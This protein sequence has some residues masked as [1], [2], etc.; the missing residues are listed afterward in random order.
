MMSQRRTAQQLIQVGNHQ[1]ALPGGVTVADWALE[2]LHWQNPRIRAF[3]GCIRLL[4]GV[5]ESNYSLLHCSPERLLD[6]WSRVRKLTDLIRHRLAPLLRG[7]SRIPLLEE[8][9]KSAELSLELLAC[10][11]LD[12]LDRVPEPVPSDQLTEIRKLLCISIGQLHAFLHDTFGELMAKDPRSLHDADYFLSRRFPQ[13]IE[14]AEWLHGT[15]ARLAEYV[16][17]L[18]QVRPVHLSAVATAM[19]ETG[20]V[21]RA[22]AWEGTRV[23]VDVLLHGLSPKLREVLALRGVR[24]QE[25]EILDRYAVE[26]P[27]QCRILLEI[28]ETAGGAAAA[29]EG[30]SGPSAAERAQ[31]ARSLRHAQGPPCHRMAELIDL[32]DATLRDLTA[33]LPL[34][35]QG[36]EKRRAMLLRKTSEESAPSSRPRRNTLR[37]HG[38]AS[39]QRYDQSL[40][41]GEHEISFPLPIYTV[42]E[43]GTDVGF[44]VILIADP[45]KSE[46][47]PTALV[48]SWRG[49]LLTEIDIRDDGH[50][51][52]FASC[53]MADGLLRL[54]G[55]NDYRYDLEL[56]SWRV[57]RRGAL[58]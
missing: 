27:T 29:I 50:R 9:R 7:A 33:F 10:H 20:V 5:Q 25:M 37:L 22:E 12:R 54:Y 34:W 58:D 32:L 21:P 38:V 56:G 35:L 57:V 51:V 46:D 39:W 6:I 11:V 19:R 42:C 14:E 26:I 52:R 36:I 43:L 49:E 1:V 4:E 40:A 15:V 2:R 28:Q 13:D 45:A 16:G 41:I 55:D 48:Y 23:F 53:E 8:A 47:Q 44:C 24:F 18:E 3:L 31:V 30:G 17:R